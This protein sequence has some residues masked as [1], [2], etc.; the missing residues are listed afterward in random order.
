MHLSLKLKITALT[1][2]LRILDN[3]KLIRFLTI[4]LA[5]ITGAQVSQLRGGWDD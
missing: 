3:A 5:E 2:F 4:Y 1:D